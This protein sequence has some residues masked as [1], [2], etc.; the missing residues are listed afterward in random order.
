M[1]RRILDAYDGRLPSD[2]IPVFA[3]TGKEREETLR[4]VYECARSWGG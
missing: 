1:F 3:N 4:F 2:V